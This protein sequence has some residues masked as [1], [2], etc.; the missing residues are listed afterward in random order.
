MKKFRLILLGVLLTACL[1]S[2]AAMFVPYTSDPAKKLA[3]AYDLTVNQG[4][5]LPAEPLIQ[6]AIESYQ[7]DS[8]EMMLANAYWTY[9][10]F[11]TSDSVK[12]FQGRYETYGFID[13]TVTY[14]TRHEKAIEYF[15]KAEAIYL[16]LKL[17]DRI[18]NIFY[19]KAM[20]YERIGNKA[21]ACESY[22][23]SLEYHLKAKASDPEAKFFL[24]QGDQS[25]EQ[26]ID[27]MLK[28]L[29]CD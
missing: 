17:D 16:K 7:K 14:A 23:V 21:K 13:K 18:G 4:R 12:S 15:D 20:V 9:G 6:E 29:K 26:Y 11:L 28:D 8:N 1:C 22:K 5:P 3:N 27:A 2:C 10:V 25:F 24:S 19:N